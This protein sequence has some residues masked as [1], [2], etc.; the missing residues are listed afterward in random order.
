MVCVYIYNGSKFNCFVGNPG[1]SG[2]S[3]LVGDDGYDVQLQPEPDL[4][5]VV[6]NFVYHKCAIFKYTF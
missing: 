2:A 1:E 6:S 4:P 3:G 5:C